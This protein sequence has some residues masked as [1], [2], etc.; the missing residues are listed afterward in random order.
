MPRIARLQLIGPLV[1]F[2]A[3]LAAEAA[4]YALAQLPSSGFLWFLNLEVFGVFRRSRAALAEFGNIPFAQTALIVGPTVIVGLVGLWLRQNLCLAL[5]SNLSFCF[6][7]FLGYNWQSWSGAAR[8]QSASLG[9]VH[10]PNDGTLW[11][12]VVLAVTSSLSFVASHFL[13][14]RAL[15]SRT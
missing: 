10:V 2:C 13:Y 14:F 9:F 5:S 15:R 7:A 4:A 11:L 1:L 8:V 3:V 12:F 6:A